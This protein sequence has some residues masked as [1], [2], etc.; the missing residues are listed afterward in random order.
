MTPPRKEEQE[1]RHWRAFWDEVPAWAKG[2][3]IALGTWAAS[4]YA[5][6]SGSATK[7]LEAKV[8]DLEISKVRIETTLDAMRQQLDRIERKLDRGRNTA[9]R[10]RAGVEG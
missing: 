7:E 1:R 6:G 4:G 10:T 5:N 2:A 3:I 9:S 8:R